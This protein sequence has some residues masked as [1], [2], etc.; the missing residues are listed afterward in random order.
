MARV[1]RDGR[2]TVYPTGWIEISGR[3][4]AGHDL[5]IT[6]GREEA[7]IL[8]QTF[9]L[10]E[11]MEDGHLGHAYWHARNPESEFPCETCH[12]QKTARLAGK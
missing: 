2:V 6:L 1:A 7:E 10:E 3:T 9:K 8:V 12:I 5:E 4:A 11:Q